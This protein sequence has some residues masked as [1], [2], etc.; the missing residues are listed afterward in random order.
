MSRKT[1]SKRRFSFDPTPER[2]SSRLRV[3]LARVPN[4]RQ[5][6]KVYGR[7]AAVFLAIGAG[8]LFPEAHELSFF[9]PF[10]IGSMLF[11]SFL[12]LE[13]G[14]QS[15]R[16]GVWKI[17]LAN[18]AIAYSGL[19]L[20]WWVER[21]LALIAFLTG[22]TPTAAAAPAVVGFLHGR[23][24][25]AVG[26]LL[27]TTVVIAAM[28]P[29]VLPLIVGATVVISSWEVLGSVLLV[30]FVP[31]ASARMARYLPESARHLLQSG[32][33][34]SF[35]LW[36]GALFLVTSKATYFI[37]HEVTV[38][39]IMLVKIAVMSLI[40]CVVNFEVGSMVGGTAF[41][42]EAS[43][44]LGQKN[45]SFTIWVALT[46]INPLVALGPTFYVI[47]HNLYSSLQLYAFE[48]RRAEHTA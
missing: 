6:V 11:F 4:R 19:F 1:S 14:R 17:L 5:L 48:K 3:F 16:Y 44:A 25:Y 26:S 15:F 38:P 7:T 46:F 36:M 37:V 20:L 34:L 22:A 35:Y 13:I 28:L 18:L 2:P 33:G 23:V 47:Y 21:D 24:E 29:F 39:A 12:G 40:I 32:K 31:L 8:V 43:Q 41:R 42:R 45:C 10:L 27:L 30:V 9:I